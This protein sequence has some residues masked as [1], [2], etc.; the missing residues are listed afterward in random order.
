[1]QRT[2]RIKNTNQQ[3]VGE[4]RIKVYAAIRDILQSDVALDDDQGSSL[5]GSKSGGGQYHLIIYTFTK[6]AS[7]GPGKRHPN[8]IAKS[9]QCLPDLRLEQHND[10]YANVEEAIAEN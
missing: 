3:I 7:M 2:G 4:F 6:L 9:N 10:R 5:R 8:S 1:M